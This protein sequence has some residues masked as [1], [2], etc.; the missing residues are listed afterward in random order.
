MR[1]DVYGLFLS[2][3][4]WGT[5]SRCFA[6]ALGNSHTVRAIAWDGCGRT[7]FVPGTGVSFG[8]PDASVDVAICIGPLDRVDEI[9]GRRRIAMYAWET[10]ILPAHHRRTLVGFD[11]IWVPSSWG[12]TILL[13]NGFAAD[14]VHVVPEGVDCR[15][16]GPAPQPPAGPFRFLSVGKWEE[17]KGISGLVRC[18]MATFAADEPVELVLHAHNPYLPGFS[19]EAALTHLGAIPGLTPEIVP[20]NPLDASGLAELF[21]SCNA[22][23]LPT[24]AEGWG[25]P[26]V[27]AM[28]SGLAVIATDY[29]APPDYLNDSNG[30]PLRAAR[31]VPVHDPFFYGT[32]EP[33]GVWAEPDWRH[34]CHLMR[35]VFD[36]PALACERG[37]RACRDAENYW[38]WDNAVRVADERLHHL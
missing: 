15:R 28:A 36:D 20:S 9:V 35:Q 14:R 25:L 5:H 22:F 37:A 32:A 12:R 30:F 33:L 26:I 13:A 16:F 4:G 27:E 3:S 21:R 34:L 23:V 8:E 10:T 18:F 29:S 11:E 7:G 2:D 31:L 17:R 1:V 24:R 38:S 19:M 6:E